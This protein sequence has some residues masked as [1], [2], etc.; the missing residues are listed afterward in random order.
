MAG[1]AEDNLRHGRRGSVSPLFEKTVQTVTYL[2]NHM[3]T[4]DF[5]GDKEFGAWASEILSAELE[6]VGAAGATLKNQAAVQKQESAESM[7]PLSE[8]PDASP[9]EGIEEVEESDDVQ[10]KEPTQE[11][12]EET[13]TAQ[14][15]D[16]VGGENWERVYY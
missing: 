5:K 8:V 16:E 6:K 7:P 10:G 9:E 2:S 11:E 15:T 12:P 1:L 4:D 3:Q 13:A 14:A